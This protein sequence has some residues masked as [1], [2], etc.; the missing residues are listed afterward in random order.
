EA[1]TQTSGQPEE[2]RE[3][4]ES[5]D[6]A[7]RVSSI[8]NI[9]DTATGP[10]EIREIIKEEWPEEVFRRVRVARENPVKEELGWDLAVWEDNEPNIEK[11]ISKMVRTRYPDFNELGQTTKAA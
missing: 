5:I 3:A 10:D 1:S 8:R 7:K 11:G 6:R 4:T 9:I 2:T